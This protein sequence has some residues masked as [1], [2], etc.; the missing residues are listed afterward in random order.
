VGAAL[1]LPAVGRAGALDVDGAAEDGVVAGAVVV[2]T[3]VGAVEGV[4]TLLV[5]VCGTGD[6][7]AGAVRCA[8]RL[9]VGAAGWGATTPP[10][11]VG[12][13]AAVGCTLR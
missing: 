5:P 4:G 1:P 8:R 6:V 12:V 11:G 13:C 10:A 9:V 7:V 2:G 3:T